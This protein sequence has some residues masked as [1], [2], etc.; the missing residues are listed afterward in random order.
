[1]NGLKSYKCLP[2]TQPIITCSKLPIETLKQGVEYVQKRT[3]ET[4][5]RRLWCHF[6]VFIVNFEHISH[7]AFMYLLLTLS[8]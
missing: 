7:L 8:R 3:M 5:E 4:P 1:M 6:D 2:L